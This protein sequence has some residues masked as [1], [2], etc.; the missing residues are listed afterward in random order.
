MWRKRSPGGR[1][2]SMRTW[3]WRTERTMRSHWRRRQSQCSKHHQR[4]SQNGP[5]KMVSCIKYVGREQLQGL[6]LV[7]YSNYLTGIHVFCRSEE[8]LWRHLGGMSH[9]RQKCIQSLRSQLL[10]I[11]WTLRYFPLLCQWVFTILHISNHYVFAREWIKPNCTWIKPWLFFLCIWHSSE[12][13]WIYCSLTQNCKQCVKGLNKKE[14]KILFYASSP[15]Q[16]Q[17][18]LSQ[19]QILA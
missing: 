12:Y 6:C 14:Q 2:S 13:L 5:R 9:F 3:G 19:V 1:A 15:C 17:E 8:H 16:Q 18:L 11:S 7:L 10:Q 4:K